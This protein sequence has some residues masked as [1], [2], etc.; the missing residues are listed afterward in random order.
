VVSFHIRL[1]AIVFNECDLSH[2]FVFWKKSKTVF[3]FFPT[4]QVSEKILNESSKNIKNA[5][6]ER[7]RNEKTTTKVYVVTLILIQ[8]YFWNLFNS[9]GSSEICKIKNICKLPSP[10]SRNTL[11]ACSEKSSWSLRTSF[12]KKNCPSNSKMASWF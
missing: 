2:D 10:F 6:I 1:S 12:W 9:S 8:N 11:I 5:L 3:R 4:R 7:L